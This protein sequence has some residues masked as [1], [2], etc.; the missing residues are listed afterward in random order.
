MR[1]ARYGYWGF[2][3]ANY[4]RFDPQ[5]DIG[6]LRA[7]VPGVVHRDDKAFHKPGVKTRVYDVTPEQVAGFDRIAMVDVQP[8]YFAGVIDRVDPSSP[9]HPDAIAAASHR[10]PRCEDDGVAQV[11]EELL[12]TVAR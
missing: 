3:P 9:L 1:D 4:R 5:K 10:A 7:G 8:H 6:K 12:S 2:S 11:L